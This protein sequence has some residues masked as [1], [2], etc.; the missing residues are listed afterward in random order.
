LPEE[1]TV[2]ELAARFGGPSI[3]F[4]NLSRRTR[5]WTSG[6]GQVFDEAMELRKLRRGRK[7]AGAERQAAAQ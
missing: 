3:D 2:A 6:P 5:L 4:Y 7:T 1:S